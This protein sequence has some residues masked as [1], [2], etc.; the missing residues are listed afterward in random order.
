M[1][2]GD[3]SDDPLTDEQ[4]RAAFDM[5]LYNQPNQNNPF[6]PPDFKSDPAETSQE[7]AD[8]R[9]IRKKLPGAM[10]DVATAEGKALQ[11]RSSAD[12]AG[13]EGNVAAAKQRSADVRGSYDAYGERIAK[14]PLLPFIPSEDNAETLGALF[15][16]VNLIGLIM[17]R[18][19]GRSSA[20]GAMKSMTGMLEGYRTG[21]KDL[22][23]REKQIFEKNYARIKDIHAQYGKE[24]DQALKLS[25]VD[26]E[27]GKANA[28]LAAKRA[29]NKYAEDMAKVGNLKAVVAAY[30]EEVK[31]IDKM[32]NIRKSEEDRKSRE[33]IAALRA[34]GKTKD[35][36]LE[37]RATVQDRFDLSIDGLNSM[38][39]ILEFKQN[40]KIE[41]EWKNNQILRYLL[42]PVGDGYFTRA[43]SQIAKSKLSPEARTLAEE[44][45]RAR[46]AYYLETSGKA[47]TGNEAMRNFGAVLQPSDT[48][49]DIMR[50]A[51]RQALNTARKTADYSAGYNF[52]EPVK[53]SARTAIDRVTRLSDSGASQ[54]SAS[55]SPAPTSTAQIEYEYRIDPLSG[56]TFRRP[57]Q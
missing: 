1:A 33:E 4:K 27:S 23:E 35:G 24:L 17:S 21:R 2:V 56:K 57:K 50:K 54:P 29:G 55:P 36:L 10:Q 20:L 14:E 42:E 25:E 45:M 11:A 26:F 41:T 51:E 38:A 48:F 16:G 7:Y 22:Y 32:N 8:L 31:I 18:G 30:T 5:G 19:A 37:P 43:A 6:V 53:Q 28:Q 52:P 39:N 3:L 46:N 12:I 15:S 49:Q 34:A 47:V 13:A 40:S 9:A 44:I